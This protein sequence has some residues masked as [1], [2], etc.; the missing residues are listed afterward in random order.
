MLVRFNGHVRIASMRRQLCLAA[1]GCGLA[2]TGW[3][4]PSPG[5]PPVVPPTAEDQ[6]RV[7][8]FGS[9]LPGTEFLQPT[10][11][12]GLPA[13][14]RRAGGELAG[15]LQGCISDNVPDLVRRWIEAFHAMYPKVVINVPPPY[16]GTG[17][18][19]LRTGEIDFC[20]ATR[21]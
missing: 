13:Y 2:G 15:S 3:A 1:L 8:Q 10:L 4:Q 5:D 12:P 20:V 14:R 6:A 19:K 16:G 21:D 18:Q 7:K 11:D 9:T 17:T